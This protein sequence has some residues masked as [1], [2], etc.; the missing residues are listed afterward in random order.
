MSYMAGAESNGISR[1]VL[2]AYQNTTGRVSTGIA[3]AT[4]TLTTAPPKFNQT[5]IAAMHC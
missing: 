4:L 3:R 5:N 2:A 1:L